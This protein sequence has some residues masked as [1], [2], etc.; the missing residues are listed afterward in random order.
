[1]L[2]VHVSGSPFLVG[3]FPETTLA[4]TV[5]FLVL[6]SIHLVVRDKIKIKNNKK[7][8]IKVQTKCR[9]QASNLEEKK[10]ESY[11]LKNAQ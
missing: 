9:V 2:E 8:N 1:M 7:I 4:V 11:I 10:K 3:H 6:L 5:C